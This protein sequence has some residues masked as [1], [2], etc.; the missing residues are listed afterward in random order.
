MTRKGGIEKRKILADPKFNSLN[1]AK[2]INMIMWDGKKGLAQSIVYNALKN[3]GE[4]TGKEPIDVFNSAIENIGP[5][6]ELKVRRVAG[7][8]YQVPTEVKPER[9][10]TLA[11]RWLVKYSRERNEKTQLIRLTNEII[12]A[13]NNTGGAVKKK[14][15]THRMA[16]ANKAY[17]NLRF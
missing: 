9:K 5:V 17:A 15:E 3:I 10:N 6:M 11:L 12:D 4:K 13:S 2:L 1:I 8:N 7:S 14:E 16:E